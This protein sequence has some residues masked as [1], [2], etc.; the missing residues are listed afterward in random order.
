MTTLKTTAV[1]PKISET[2]LSKDC[3]I[4]LDNTQDL[5]TFLKLCNTSCMGTMKIN[6]KNVCK[7]VKEKIQKNE[8]IVQ[9]DGP[10]CIL[11]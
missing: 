8:V 6:R 10:V 1:I 11:R 5:V 2:L 9:Y 3:V 7:K 4:W